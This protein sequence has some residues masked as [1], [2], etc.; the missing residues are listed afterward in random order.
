MARGLPR[1]P[2]RG[3]ALAGG[4]LSYFTRH[5]TVANLLMVLMVAAGIG[6]ATQLRTQFFPDVVTPEIVVN[7]RWPGAGSEDMDRGLV[8]PLQPGLLA[9]D[10]LD[11]MVSTVRE[12]WGTITLRFDPSHDIAE[13]HE[14]VQNAINEVRTLPD[15][16]DDPIVRRGGW[17]DRVTDVV[18]A[19]PLPVEQLALLADELTARLFAAGITR[20]T[21]EGIAA[22][23]ILIEVPGASLMRHDI[24]LRDIA[25]AVAAEVAAR[26]AG[27][28][29]GGSARVRAGIE[30]RTAE[31]LGAIVLR[32]GADGETLTVGDIATVRV[33]APDRRQARFV[34]DAPAMV[35]RVDRNETGDAIAI[36]NDV[37]RVA[38]EM[39]RSVPAGT[40]VE[41]IRARAD[42]ISARLLLLIDNG[43]TG[44]AI[45]LALLFLFL[46]ARTAF[47]VAAGIPVAMCAALAAMYAAGLT[48]NM[49]SLFALII[50]LGIVVDDAIIVGEHADHRARHLGEPAEVAAENAARAMGPPVL[51][52]TLTT[53]AAFMGMLAISGRFGAMIEAIPFTVVAVLVASLIECFLVL[54]HHMAGALRHAAKER[55][56]DRPSRAVNRGFDVIRARFFRPFV[57]LVLRARFAVLALALLALATQ[58]AV[59]VRGDV[60]WRFFSGPERSTVTGSFAM[61][62]SATRDDTVAMIRELQRA[63]QAV[64]ERYEAMHGTW[65][66]RHVMGEMGGNAGRALPG[67]EGKDPDQRGAVSMELIDPDLRPYS[68]FEFRAAVAEEVRPHPRLEELSFRG[69]FAGP[70][71]DSLSVE[72]AGSDATVLKAA[73]EA[74]KAALAAY[75]SVSG[76]EDSLNYDKEELIVTLKPQGEALGFSAAALATQ[77]RERLQGIEAAT[78]PDGARSA[79]IRIELPP[80]ERGPD[81]LQGLQL[82]APS[83]GWVPL[84]D[85]VAVG[86][87][88]GFSSVRRTNGLRVVSV[89][90]ELS[91]DD[92]AAA[93]EVERVLEDELLPRLERDFGVTVERSGLAQQERA[94]LSDAMLGFALCLLVIY[95]ILAWIFASWLR[96]VVVMAVIPFG[97]VGAVWGHVQ[98]DIPLSTFSVIGLIGMTGIIINDSIV[99]IDSVERGAQTRGLFPAIVDGT[100]DRLRAVLLTT[101][102]TVLGLAPLLFETSSQAQFLKPTVITLVYG[103]GFGM[104]LVLVVIPALLAVQRDMVRFGQSL[105]RALRTPLRF[106]PAGVAVAAAAL[107]MAAAGGA[108]IAPVVAAGALPGPLAALVPG[109]PP[110]LGAAMLFAPAAVAAALLA[111]VAALLARRLGRR[112]PLP[113]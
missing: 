56:Y 60:Q 61:L 48:L 6:A 55:W 18:I 110:A 105:R 78:F 17:R 104:V 72:L 43:A 76:L 2:R 36:Q 9:V 63:T 47:W 58:V 101:L 109:L 111:L 73:A 27:N 81:F 35:V 106:G 54:P 28:V 16:A 41:L 103:L 68:S 59:V 51:A 11:S 39:Q 112:R 79:E 20:T 89:T 66:L 45:V 26:P 22:P 74:L 5:P 94:F 42:E 57:R 34:G 30:R 86:F 21:V 50:T 38:A 82:R 83:G 1:R 53:A 92:P 99:L 97:L 67:A 84:A 37:A 29:S 12:G 113:G 14:A 108:T 4:I 46:N 100:A 96:P 49:M 95:L 87:Q 80:G 33:Q 77:L 40:T 107:A 8:Q 93:A 31:T 44:L 13:A 85:I 32:R 75:P 91:A 24:G 7:L 25:T 98:W 10:G 102:T 23:G 90:G 70:A 88:A 64:A 65:P 15:D 71:D 69:S 62:S 52:S 19:G 3:A